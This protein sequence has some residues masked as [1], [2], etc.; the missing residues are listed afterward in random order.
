MQLS[1]ISGK[2]CNL[3]Q[4]VDVKKAFVCSYLQYILI[5]SRRMKILC[6]MGVTKNMYVL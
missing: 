5:R 1:W 2:D 3:G 6:R 4:E